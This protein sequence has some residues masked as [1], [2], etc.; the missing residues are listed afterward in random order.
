[1]AFLTGFAHFLG[2][3]RWFSVSP[4]RAWLAAL[5][6]LTTLAAHGA[7]TSCTPQAG[8]TACAQF[9]YSGGDQ[10]FVAPA[11]IT[12]LNVKAWGAGGGGAVSNVYGNGS[13]GGGYATGNLAVAA[14]S[15]LTVVVGGGGSAAATSA[16]AGNSAYGGG[17]AGSSATGATPLVGG[18]GG[19]RSAVQLTSTERLTA[20]GGGGGVVDQAYNTF[21]VAGAGGGMTGLAGSNYA[22]A[23]C[24]AA[25]GSGGQGGTQSAGGAGG[26]SVETAR[27]GSA[28][29]ALQGG[30]GG[31]GV[32]FASSTGN[33][34]GGGGGGGYNG[35]GGGNGDSNFTCGSQTAGGGGSSYTGA[36]TGASTTP[37]A[38]SVAGNAGDSVYLAGVGAGGAQGAAG[39]NGLV[40][41]QYNVPPVITS[42]MTASA[43]PLLGGVS[44]Q[45]YTLV[46]NVATAPTTAPIGISD[47]FPANIV[48]SGTPTLV[49]G[50]AVLS[51]CPSGGGVTNGCTVAAGAAIGSFSIRFP[52]S[53]STTA[54]S[55]TTSANLSG[56]GDPNCTTVLPDGCDATPRPRPS[57][58]RR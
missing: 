52:I 54:T 18:G 6:V 40:V 13:A 20:G 17:G 53:V 11:G 27:N 2:K 44:G 3:A 33:S 50:T 19:G 30:A 15:S 34:G 28:G 23:G 21:P 12:S 46:V 24:G 38:G 58:T 7:Q 39:G 43:N 4:H 31:T 5:T 26:V 35:G 55:G 32:P 42:S 51:G 37:G 45:Y 56:G 25:V 49:G 16:A 36:L 41:I 22:L 48:L 1:M 47:T 9:S 14:G 29:T 10:T 8:F 57:T